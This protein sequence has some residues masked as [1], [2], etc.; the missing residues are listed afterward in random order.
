MSGFFLDF[1][2]FNQP[3]TELKNFI[4]SAENLVLPRESRTTAIP[5]NLFKGD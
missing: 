1:A 3:D 4:G 2:F 5:Y